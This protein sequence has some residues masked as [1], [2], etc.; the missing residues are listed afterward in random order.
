MNL[1]ITFIRLKKQSMFLN[2][3]VTT[4]LKSGYDKLFSFNIY[5]R[6]YSALLCYNLR[7]I[8]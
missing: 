6:Y 2:L 4:T 8:E 5:E 1:K 3:N 7:P